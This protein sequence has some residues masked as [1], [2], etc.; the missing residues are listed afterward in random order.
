MQNNTTPVFKKVWYSGKK[1]EKNIKNTK[2][3]CRQKLYKARSFGFHKI[4][5][6]FTILK[7]NAV[8]SNY[9]FC[10]SYSF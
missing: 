5:K 10:M 8:W 3:I 9:L 6:P 1:V 4:K 7:G 2:I